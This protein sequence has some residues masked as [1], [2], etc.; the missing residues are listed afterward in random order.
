MNPKRLPSLE[1]NEDT[2]PWLVGIGASAGGLDALS[3]L[4]RGLPDR[5]T[6]V[7]A[8]HMSASRPSLLTEVL[9][10]DPAFP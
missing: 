6:Y 3:S 5:A 10:R 9:S 2:G 8:Q 7:I 4:L 1:R